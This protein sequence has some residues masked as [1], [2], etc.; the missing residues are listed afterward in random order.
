MGPLN[1]IL[2]T[3]VWSSFRSYLQRRRL[4]PLFFS[5]LRTRDTSDIPTADISLGST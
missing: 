4:P 3:A 5:T 2:H 1:Q